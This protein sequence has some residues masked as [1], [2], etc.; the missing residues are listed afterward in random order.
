M[1]Y[2]LL[3]NDP[4]AGHLFESYRGPLLVP[5]TERN[6]RTHVSP[7]LTEIFIEK[8]SVCRDDLRQM[9]HASSLGDE[10]HE[11]LHET[12]G[13]ALLGYRYGDAA[14]ICG[15]DPGPRE[16]IAHV[17]M[18]HQHVLEGLQLVT[19]GRCCACLACRQEQRLGV[20][21]RR[22]LTRAHWA[23]GARWRWRPRRSGGGRRHAGSS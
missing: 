15:L 2:L 16:H 20:P 1:V 13:A 11:V 23:P 14:S 19:R 12:S 8:R 9:I 18:R 5:G 21:L 17:R 22:Y 6:S 4:L 10:T 3:Q 7:S